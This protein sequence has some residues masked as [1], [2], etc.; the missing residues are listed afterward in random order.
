MS[1]FTF[2]CLL[3]DVRRRVLIDATGWGVR[4]AVRRELRIPYDGGREG[5]WELWS[6]TCDRLPGMSA[7]RFLNFRSR[8]FG[9]SAATA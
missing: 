1:E 9:A 3:Y 5:Q 4:D 6:T 8:G 7:L 2:N